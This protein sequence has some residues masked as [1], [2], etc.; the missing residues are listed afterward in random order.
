MGR[1]PSWSLDYRLCMDL[2]GVNV[3]CSAK[4]PSNFEHINNVPPGSNLAKPP[5]IPVWTLKTHHISKNPY[6]L[7]LSSK[8]HCLHF[9][10]LAQSSKVTHLIECMRVKTLET[11]IGRLSLLFALINF[12]LLLRDIEGKRRDNLGAGEEYKQAKKLVR[13][14]N[15]S[16]SAQLSV[17]VSHV[18]WTLEWDCGDS[19]VLVWNLLVELLSISDCL[20]LGLN[21]VLLCDWG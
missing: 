14:S 7:P 8:T 5:L 11:E 10:T 4:V 18:L 15:N 17:D 20:S 19:T 16:T 9:Y 6:L 12:N 1:K 21:A 13:I 2:I 3:G